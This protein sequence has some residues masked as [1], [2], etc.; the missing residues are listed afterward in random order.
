MNR[1]NPII[2]PIATWQP[3]FRSQ[4]KTIKLLCT[5][6][7][8]LTAFVLAFFVIDGIDYNAVASAYQES[9][10]GSPKKKINTIAAIVRTAKSTS[11]PGR[12]SSAL[13]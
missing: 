13:E 4:P 11:K 9:A 1:W 10:D 7:W 3:V 8:S 2:K 6:T 5:G 12:S